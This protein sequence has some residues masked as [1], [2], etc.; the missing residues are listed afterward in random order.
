MREGRIH[1]PRKVA[2]CVLCSRTLRSPSRFQL[3][4]LLINYHICCVHFQRRPKSNQQILL[5]GSTCARPIQR[6]DGTR[7]FF[8]YRLFFTFRIRHIAALN[9][10]QLA[11]SMLNSSPPDK[12]TPEDWLL[13]ATAHFNRCHTLNFSLFLCANLVCRRAV[14]MEYLHDRCCMKEYTH[15]LEALASS[16]LETPVFT[17]IRSA[18]CAALQELETV[19]RLSPRRH[20]RSGAGSVVLE[21]MVGACPS[22]LCRRGVL[23][24]W[25]A[26]SCF[27]VLSPP[28][29]LSICLQRFHKGHR[30]V[31]NT[32]GR[33]W[34]CHKTARI[35]TNT[36]R[37]GRKH[38]RET[39]TM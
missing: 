35:E 8:E 3:N 20:T 28:P 14:E 1:S 29:C 7:S 10:A 34:S 18:C 26:C 22:W 32:G 11:L 6:K 39:L 17:T 24:L 37:E 30:Q 4:V 33:M 12:R 31:R 36:R 2:Q 16:K 23:I 38:I 5:I 19:V 21:V 13:I 9:Q 15:C 25:C 27:V